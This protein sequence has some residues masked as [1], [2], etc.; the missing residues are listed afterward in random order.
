MHSFGY[1]HLLLLDLTREGKKILKATAAT[2]LLPAYI[3]K[4]WEKSQNPHIC[5]TF[6]RSIT[7]VSVSI[8]FGALELLSLIA[9]ECFICHTQTLET[10]CLYFSRFLQDSHTEWN[11]SAN[12]CYTSWMRYFVLPFSCEG[13]RNRKR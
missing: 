6:I 7:F 9:R 10:L 4:K 3:L 12:R 11:L 1:F 8:H 2:K 13:K 5:T